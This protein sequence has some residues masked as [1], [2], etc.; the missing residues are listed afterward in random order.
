M[1]TPTAS[2]LFT[3]LE[4]LNTPR[5]GRN[6][7]IVAAD[8]HADVVLARER[9]VRRIDAH[10]PGSR[11]ST[12]PAD[13]DAGSTTGGA[14]AG[15]TVGDNLDPERVLVLVVRRGAGLAQRVQAV[16]RRTR[17]CCG[18]SRKL[19]DH[20]RAAIE[21]IQGERQRRP[22]G[23]HLDLGTGSY[24]GAP[25]YSE[26]LAIAAENDWRLRRSGRSP[27]ST[28]RCA[29]TGS[30]ART[31]SCAL[32]DGRASAAPPPTT[33]AETASAAKRQAPAI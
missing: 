7:G 4:P 6:V 31:G 3:P 15:V 22:F 33:A 8:G 19:E 18:E 9:V 30:G 10:L 2:S 14:G 1:E 24:V 11:R 25:G 23:G 5:V 21:F 29:T 28:T 26:V 17:R 16:L 20:P 13:L 32:T 12:L 27:E